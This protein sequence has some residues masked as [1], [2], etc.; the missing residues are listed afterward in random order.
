[1]ENI[2]KNAIY[3]VSTP[4]GNLQDITYRAVYIL[5]SVDMILCEDTRVSKT[6]FNHYEIKS[7]YATMHNFNEKDIAQEWVNKIKNG[8]SV[9]IISDAGTPLIADPGFT[10][11]A[12]AIENNI[13]IIPISGSSALLHALVG[14]GLPPY[15]FYF[16]GFLPKKN[17][18]IKKTL[19]SLIEVQ[20][21]LIFYESPKRV[22]ESLSFM[23]QVYGNRK[24]VLARELSKKFETFYRGFLNDLDIL[25]MQLKGECVILLDGYKEI[26]KPLDNDAI[27]AYDKLI[28]QGIDSKEAL[29]II[30]QEYH[31]SK[32]TLY[33]FIKITHKKDKP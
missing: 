7:N 4:I 22:K 27:D 19:S 28:K 10:L 26:D 20:A 15:P 11:I 13:Q 3:I 29:R 5:K 16:H 24:F 33:Q 9:A 25:D 1:M 8:L 12:L 14:S 6:L 21:T 2:N 23:Y 31:V 18:Q 32:N 17:E 30:S